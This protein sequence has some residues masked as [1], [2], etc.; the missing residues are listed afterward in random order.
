MADEEGFVPG[1]PMNL[2]GD[3]G[4][5][6]AKPAEI[7]MCRAKICDEATGAA[8]SSTISE[9]MF[10]PQGAKHLTANELVAVVKNKWKLTMANMLINSDAGSMHPKA[11][12]TKKLSSQPQFNDWMEQSKAQLMKTQVDSSP[13]FNDP[14]VLKEQSNIVINQLIFQRLLTI[15]S[16]VLDAASLSNNWIFINRANPAGSSATGQYMLE[17]AM[18]QTSQRPVVIVIESLGRIR[19]FFNDDAVKQVA[20]LDALSKKGVPL[21]DYVSSEY[22]PVKFMA[23]YDIEEFDDYR[24]WVDNDLP[25]EP[26]KADLA[27]DTGKV[28]ERARWGYHYQS[29]CFTSGTHYIILDGDESSFP[30]QALGTVGFVCAHGST[31]AYQRLRAVI[32]AGRPLVM[33]NNT[34]GVT[35]AF[36]SLH[37]ALMKGQA[38]GEMLTSN[39][40]LD[41]IE[42]MN[43]VDQWTKTF[44]IPEIM[45][46]REL[47]QR[48]P[49]LF[50]K[51]IVVVDLVKDSAE[52]VLG[53]V[54]GCFAASG[55]GVPELGIGN[56][57]TAVVYN[58]WKRHLVLFENRKALQQ[59]GNS[60]FI[61]LTVLG[62]STASLSTIYANKA[63]I[64][65]TESGQ[66]LVNTFIIILP[67]L[68]ALIGQVI[69]RQR[70]AEKWKI[71]DMASSLIVSEIYMFRA[72]TGPY[73]GGV[74]ASSDEDDE[75]GG[76]GGGGNEA[77]KKRNLFVKRIQNIF[78]KVME[79]DV[80]KSGA[81]VYGQILRMDTSDGVES[82]FHKILKKHIEMNLV[83]TKEP[84]KN[85]TKK[86]GSDKIS[87]M[88]SMVSKQKDSKQ[89]TIEKDDFVSPIT[90]ETYFEYRAIPLALA[91]EKHTPAISDKLS[92]LEIT[93]FVLTSAG[94]VLAVPGVELGSWVAITVALSTGVTSYI[95]YFQLRVE[96]DTR[97]NSL[98][99]FQNLVTWWESLSIID[100]R[101]K[102]SKEKALSTIENGVLILVERRAGAA[103]SGG[104]DE[105]E[106]G[107]GDGGDGG[108]GDGKEE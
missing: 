29:C 64:G 28:G 19:T 42:I 98:A 88:P 13:D 55:S 80:G 50:Q 48:A 108:D 17:L 86:K 15:F 20:S 18:Q 58:A 56:A 59:M 24:D 91:Y 67:I 49:M 21:K 77:S 93:V 71:C 72:S 100:K 101:T 23:A 75:G 90:I 46:F 25:C 7:V 44:G 40:L 51:T 11:L 5:V 39:E 95:E 9:F 69:T 36:A 79:S 73:A 14:E 89:S 97:N 2:V 82:K 83:F 30:S 99:E 107:G 34:G 85:D 16:A 106:E 10:V 66:A 68:T 4:S 12:A 92:F 84:P 35:Q 27:P 62:V 53:T 37:K 65:M 1:P 52:D 105:E 102:Q 26:H 74:V 38:D 22:E 54:T 61:W 70:Y 41:K 32:Q 3:D 43:N 60:L 104:G 63:D 45:M 103:F 6:V 47:A 33:M 94:A 8:K 96:R 81:L 57:E 31:R 87:T 76:G 78:S